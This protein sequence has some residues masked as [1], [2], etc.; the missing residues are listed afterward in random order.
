MSG[1][2]TRRIDR[3]GYVLAL[4]LVLLAALFIMAFSLGAAVR[5][6]LTQ[7][8]RFQDQT[9]AEF[10]ARGGIEWVIHYLN[11]LD[12]QE[13]LW[14][15]PWQRQ[16]TLFQEHRLG[17]GT[18]EIAYVDVAG[19]LRYGFRDEEARV[20]LNRASA[21][22]LA[23]LPG[24][25]TSAAAEIV[26]RRQRRRWSRPEALVEAGVLASPAFSGTASA[27][28]LVAY[29]TTWGSGKINLN[30]APLPVLAAVPGLTPQQAAA[31]VRYRR[32]IDAQAGTADDQHFRRLADVARVPGLALTELGRALEV[33]TVEPTTF[34]V[35]V[36]GRVRGQHGAVQR[37]RRL[38]IV[39][40]SARPV[41]VQ[42]WQQPE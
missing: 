37:H 5:S 41:R 23:S 8:R 36:T 31:I 40:R 26:A 42:Y 25:G 38:A 18:F 10:V 4:V 9:A 11:Q 16:Q 32:G 28:G 34:R 19:D 1:I 39:D 20:N 3:R 27:P 17:P 2:L 15:A 33:L 7:S 22:L 21:D 30:T 13:A 12:R 35:V 24:L 14:Q 6:N 29:L